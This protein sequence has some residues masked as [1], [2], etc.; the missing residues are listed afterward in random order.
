[1]FEKVMKGINTLGLPDVAVVG[2]GTSI[3]MIALIRRTNLLTLILWT[4]VNLIKC[5]PDTS[6]QKI[7]K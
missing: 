1:M 2:D 6:R 7:L 5:L 3:K 4:F